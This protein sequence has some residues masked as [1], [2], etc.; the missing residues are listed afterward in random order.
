MDLGKI[1]SGSVGTLE[2]FLVWGIEHYPAKHYALIIAGHGASWGGVAWDSSTGSYMK[3][4]DLSDMLHRVAGNTGIGAFDVIA[5][6]AC[7]MG[8]IEVAEE[9]SDNTN[10]MVA[11]AQMVD[12]A[13]LNYEG[14]AQ[15]I[16]GQP[17][18]DG[19]TFGGLLVQTFGDYYAPSGTSYMLVALDTAKIAGV[20][21][22]LD[23]LI[24][25]LDPAQYE[26]VGDAY[27][28]SFAYMADYYA[29]LGHLAENVADLS[30]DE[31]VSG[32]ALALAQAID[33][34][35]LQRV[36]G[37]VGVDAS[38]LSIYFPHYT[39]MQPEYVAFLRNPV[40]GRWA[41]WVGEMK[42]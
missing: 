21:T 25:V 18:A 35:V 15:A 14:F 39:D 2:A 20:I 10:V 19:E 28:R 12:Y 34:A 6:D 30:D 32:A 7:L 23:D 27:N 8:G 16:L 24:A 9:L 37:P 26:I 17:D 31:T 42:K 22:A 11:S 33:E 3:I 4:V 13:G 40:W 5:F 41:A 36:S 38:G 29:D 1:D